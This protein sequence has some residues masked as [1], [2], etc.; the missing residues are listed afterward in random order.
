MTTPHL[1]HFWEG[2]YKITLSSGEQVF[3]IATPHGHERAEQPVMLLQGGTDGFS[4]NPG[5]SRKATA[6]RYGERVVGKKFPPFGGTMKV[7]VGDPSLRVSLAHVDRQWRRAWSP[8][9]DTICTVAATDG[10]NAWARFRLVDMTDVPNNLRA[11]PSYPCDVSWTCLD[12]V[13][14]GKS[15]TYTGTAEVRDNSDAGLSPIVSLEWDTTQ[16]L[17]VT[18][19]DGRRITFPRSTATGSLPPIVYFDL[20]PGMMGH[21]TDAPDGDTMFTLWPAF[22]GKMRGVE[23]IPRKPSYWTLSG[24]TLRVTP[25]YLHPWR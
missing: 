19:P 23:L 12:G 14:F 18:F 4:V 20:E 13:W 15:R 25:R 5:V 22:Q 6:N 21:P 2:D 24:C 11:R 3:N 1:T 8:F 7:V 17:D 9:E 16:D 10:G